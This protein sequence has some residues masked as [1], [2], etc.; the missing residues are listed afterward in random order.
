M[1]IYGHVIQAAHETTMDTLTGANI[2]IERD[3]KTDNAR[4]LPTYF[5]AEYQIPS[6]LGNS[7]LQP[8]LNDK[9]GQ[10]LFQ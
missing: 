3:R 2:N 1:M 9:N 4:I 5:V 7:L 10:F 8:L 6:Q